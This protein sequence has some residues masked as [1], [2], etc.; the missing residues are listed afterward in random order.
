MKL[1]S[2]SRQPIGSIRELST[3]KANEGYMKNV[4]IQMSNK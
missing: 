1:H 4:F 3:F 2:S